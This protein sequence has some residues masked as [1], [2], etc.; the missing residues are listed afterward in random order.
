[1]EKIL[2][3]NVE[4]FIEIAKEYELELVEQKVLQYGVN[5]KFCRGSASS[6][7]TIYYGKKKGISI[8]KSQ[9]ESSLDILFDRAINELLGIIISPDELVATSKPKRHV[10]TYSDDEIHSWRSWI[11]SDES[12]KGDF[13]GPLVVTAF[14]CYHEDIKVLREMGVQDSKKLTAPMILKIAEKIM[15]RFP[16][17]YSTFALIPKKYNELYVNFGKSGKKLDH[18]LAWM[19]SKAIAN[20]VKL[21]TPEGLVIDKFTSERIISPFLN[22]EK[23]D[24][25]LKLIPK[26][27]RDVAVAAASILARYKYVKGMDFYS[28][29][30]G[31]TLPKGGGKQ[32]LV[33]GREF[34]KLHSKEKLVE[35]AK[36]HFVNY[37]KL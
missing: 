13:F 36:L 28:K 15:E 9:K 20:L 35:V 18:L 25:D 27:E 16:K 29:S 14:H 1:M 2:K 12:G 34:I 37:T 5:L 6:N 10:S 26:G 3:E 22:F 33:A 31:L 4:Q 32:T 7:L 17:Q 11:G 30:Y 23:L 19:H 21:S 8:V 24:Y